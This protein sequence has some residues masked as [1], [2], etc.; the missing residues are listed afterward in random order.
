MT[1]YYYNKKTKDYMALHKV[2]PKDVPAGYIEISEQKY[3]DQHWK[4]DVDAHQC[5][6]DEYEVI[7]LK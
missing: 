6:D 3:N 1:K 4:E 5:G 2:T 7:G